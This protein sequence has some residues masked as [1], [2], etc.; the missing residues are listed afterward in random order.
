MDLHAERFD[1]VGP[2]GAAR[3]IGEVELDL[4]PPLVELHGHGADEGLDA[5]AGL[6]FVCGAHDQ[7]RF[8]SV[9]DSMP[10][11]DL[12]GGCAEAAA[13]VL[14]VQHLHLEG[15]V[16]VELRKC[17]VRVVVLIRT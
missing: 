12:E 2:V 10:R 13:D 7:Y 15:E 5:R 4:V 8:E 11:S 1:V 17:V 3:E 16:L 9:S 14:V 6:W